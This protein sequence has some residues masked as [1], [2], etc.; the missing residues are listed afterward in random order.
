MSQRHS[1]ANHEAWATTTRKAHGVPCVHCGD[2]TY[3]KNGVCVP[4]R[5]KGKQ[6][7]APARL[8]EDYL[9]RCAQELLRRHNERNA[10]LVKL[11]IKAVAA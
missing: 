1:G 4:C 6:Y 2:L 10:L 5:R 7:V 11:G 9:M 8:P 3:A